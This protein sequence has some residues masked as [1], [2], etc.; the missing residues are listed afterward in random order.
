MDERRCCDLKATQIIYLWLLCFNHWI[1]FRGLKKLMVLLHKSNYVFHDTLA[2]TLRQGF[3]INYA[4]LNR[5][6]HLQNDC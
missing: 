4:G 5:S 3:I 6:L 2:V 1:V